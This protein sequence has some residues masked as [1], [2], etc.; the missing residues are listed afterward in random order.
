MVVVV[1]VVIIV[2]VVVAVAVAVGGWWWRRRWWLQPVGLCNLYS[3]IFHYIMCSALVLMCYCVF[4][5]CY[6]AALFWT[7]AWTRHISRQLIEW[8]FLH[9][10]CQAVIRCR[11]PCRRASTATLNSG[12][13]PST[14]M[15]PVSFSVVAITRVHAGSEVFENG[16]GIF[17]RPSKFIE[18]VQLS[19]CCMNPE[20][21][22]YDSCIVWGVPVIC[23]CALLSWQLT[24]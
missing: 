18:Y 24:D 14:A 8:Y 16:G 11:W 5:L 6:C 19:L 7:P 9:A 17:C 2:V 20:L 23:I 10:S 3:D 1:V 15:F 12:R 21:H 4:L 13:C 22:M